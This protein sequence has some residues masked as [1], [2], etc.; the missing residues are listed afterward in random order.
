MDHKSIRWSSLATKSY[1]AGDNTA[2]FSTDIK[3]LLREEKKLEEW[4]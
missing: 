1:S 3:Y 2:S 4:I